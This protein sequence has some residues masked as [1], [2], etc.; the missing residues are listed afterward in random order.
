MQEKSANSLVPQN[1]GSRKLI[2]KVRKDR[3]DFQVQVYFRD[4]YDI[5]E[6]NKKY[7]KLKGENEEVHNS[8]IQKLKILPNYN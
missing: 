5:K 1:P 3:E 8:S 4:P 7:N 6:F 2:L